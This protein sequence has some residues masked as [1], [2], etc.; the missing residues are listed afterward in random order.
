MVVLLLVVVSDDDDD[1]DD[2]G[3]GAGV[4]GDGSGDG[5]GGG[6][7]DDDDAAYLWCCLVV[8]GNEV[9]AVFPPTDKNKTKKKGM[10]DTSWSVTAMAAVVVAYSTASAFFLGY[11]QF[12][13]P[14]RTLVE[15]KSSCGTYQLPL[16]YI[17]RL[18]RVF[19][20]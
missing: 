18:V 3:N 20:F 6:D 12:R 1:D 2:D 11:A 7:E 15:A 9:A 17:R 16:L 10:C 8:V 4:D 5:G 13:L 19:F 14:T